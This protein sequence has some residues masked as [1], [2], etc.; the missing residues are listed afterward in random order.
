M[1]AAEVLPSLVDAS[2]EAVQIWC[3]TNSTELRA[4]MRGGVR[5][6]AVS[7]ALTRRLFD[8]KGEL[9]RPT[10]PVDGNATVFQL[11]AASIDD[12]RFVSSPDAST[13]GLALSLTVQR[14][15][16]SELRAA[17]HAD[18]T[19][20][21]DCSDGEL[22]LRQPNVLGDGAPL[23][24]VWRTGG[25]ARG[26]T[27]VFNGFLF[28]AWEEADE[29][30]D[31]AVPQEGAW[32]LL[33]ADVI[34]EDREQPAQRAVREGRE[35]RWGADGMPDSLRLR[36][37]VRLA[38]VI[39]SR[40]GAGPPSAAFFEE[41]VREGGDDAALKAAAARDRAADAAVAAALADEAVKHCWVQW[42]TE[43]GRWQ[44][45]Q[46]GTARAQLA[47]RSQS[48]GISRARMRAA[49]DKSGAAGRA[50]ALARLRGRGQ[51][52]SLPGQDTC[53]VCL[54]ETSAMVCRTLACGHTFHRRCIGAW[55]MQ[56]SQCP[57][58][59]QDVPVAGSAAGHRADVS[60]PAWR[61]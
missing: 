24:A 51:P 38:I 47:A 55:L 57:L 22:E 26:D 6:T 52:Q 60:R 25:C 7:D 37:A 13:A 3:R 44:P 18:K 14:T 42:P 29:A 15:D 59:K 33:E 2:P 56:K 58:C 17:L 1:Y 9:R 4:A 36:K 53:A 35:A 31:T 20:A 41:F 27:S 5:A 30:L 39:N 40:W 11:H 12:T 23:F 21:F 50:A 48:R 49:I 10:L 54:E 16:P 19:G 61:Y 28:G 43:G 32:P 45:A 34:E 8:S 46:W